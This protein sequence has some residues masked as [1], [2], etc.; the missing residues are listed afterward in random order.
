LAT[1][2]IYA[3]AAVLI[4]AWPGSASVHMSVSISS[5]SL[6]VPHSEVDDT[7]GNHKTAVDCPDAEHRR[8]N[9]LS[10]ADC[11]KGIFTSKAACDKHRL[12]KTYLASFPGSGNTWLRSSLEGITGIFTGSVFCD[13]SLLASGF[14]GECHQDQD[15]LIAV[16][17][18]FPDIVAGKDVQRDAASQAVV[19]VRHPL[20]AIVAE[21]Q[22]ERGNTSNSDTQHVEEVPYHILEPFVESRF[23]EMLENWKKH[24]EWWMNEFTGRRIFVKY[25]DLHQKGT[26]LKQILPFLKINTENPNIMRSLTCQLYGDTGGEAFHR[27][28]SY[29]YKFTEKQIEMARTTVGHLL[30]KFNYSPHP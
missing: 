5:S 3:S 15:K 10:Q 14:K 7:S 26:Y 4:F 11:H 8:T 9:F 28:H 24:T 12:T 22:R 20:N 25:E 18:H 6:Q 13:K 16:K 23:N 30:R 19:L 21:C 29:T 27:D 1:C 2:C 17:T